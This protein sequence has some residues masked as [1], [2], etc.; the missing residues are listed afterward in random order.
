MKCVHVLAHAVKN[1]DGAREFVGAVCDVTA[2]RVADEKIRRSETEYRQIIDAIPQLIV[3]MS[4]VGQILYINQ[5]ALESTG[6]T[7][8]DALADDFRTRLFHPEDLVRLRQERRHGMVNGTPFELEM[9]AR[10]KDGRYRWYLVHYKPVLNEEKRISRWY[11]TGTDINHARSPKT[12]SRTR[13]WPCGRRSTARPCS[14]KLS[15]LQRRCAPSFVKSR[16]SRRQI[17]PCSSPAKRVRARNWSH[18]PFISGPR[19]R[20]ARLSASMPPLCLRR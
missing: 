15:A 14:R 7:M 8:S 13:T 11:A 20:G 6:L 19:D 16:R 3:A 1:A 9:R 5:S 17:R 18:V 4:P 10:M 12:K 2:A